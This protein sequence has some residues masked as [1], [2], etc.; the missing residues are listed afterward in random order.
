VERVN[1]V[2]ARE[3]RE[4]TDQTEEEDQ[5]RKLPPPTMPGAQLAVAS[6]A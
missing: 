5:R 2:A 3:T 1:S 4:V 6:T